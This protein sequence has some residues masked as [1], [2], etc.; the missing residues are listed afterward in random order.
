MK[1]SSG[2]KFWSMFSNI[3]ILILCFIM[4]YPFVYVFF[5]SISDPV[6]VGAHPVTFYP[7][8]FTMDNYKAVFQNNTILLSLLVTVSRTLV[9][10]FLHLVVTG[11]VAYAL[12]KE[13]L[14]WKNFF[15]AFFVIPMYFGGGLLPYYVLITKLHLT[16]NF[17]V[18]V[19]PTAFGVFNMLIMKVY[20]QQLPVS[21]EESA[22]IDGAGD[23]LIF[24]RIIVPSSMPIIA[25]VLMFIGVL[26]WNSW[27]DAF[28]F[29]NKH[30]LMPLQT[31]LYKIIL[32]NE[33]KTI[34]DI[35]KLSR[36]G[37]KVT[38]EAIK[39]S[40]LIVATAPIVAIYPFLQKYFV[41]GMLLGAVKA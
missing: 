5:Y 40:S 19:L 21:L 13:K 4:I 20:F 12:S 24:A 7:V 25:T 31:I 1:E 18:Y 32:E 11:L 2:E 34:E 26:Q 16:N 23:F 36:R 30:E 22:R 39:M 17:L 37:T 14:L 29:V 6:A 38:P 3:A 15:I 8:G 35:M 41:K 28:L 27:F 33:A 9:G 10:S